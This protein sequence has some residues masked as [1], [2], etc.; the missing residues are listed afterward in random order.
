MEQQPIFR[1]QLFHLVNRHFNLDELQLIC[2]ELGVDYQHLA[3]ENKLVKITNLILYIER[4]DSLLQ[5]DKLLREKRP[6]V[7]WPELPPEFLE[8]EVPTNNVPFS[9]SMAGKALYWLLVIIPMV[10]HIVINIYFWQNLSN[11]EV[12]TQFE[13]FLFWIKFIWFTPIFWVAM[14][15][16]GLL[17]GPPQDVNPTTNIQGAWDE[18]NAFLIVSYVSKGINQHTLYRTIQETRGVLDL[19]GINYTIEVV[20]DIEI[21]QGKRIAAING[22]IIT[23]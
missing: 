9:M 19:K 7:P 20:T 18:T 12:N 4:H 22:A 11:F 23:P 14:N 17:Q 13:Q 21:S 15:I 10:L 6:T 16:L 2:F 1:R 5:L 8:D 3:G